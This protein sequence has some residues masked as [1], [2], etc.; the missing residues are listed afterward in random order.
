MRHASDHAATRLGRGDLESWHAR[1]SLRFWRPEDGD[2]RDRQA[3]ISSYPRGLADIRATSAAIARVRERAAVLP[4]PLLRGG[5][6]AANPRRRTLD[7][8]ERNAERS[9]GGSEPK[10]EEWVAPTAFSYVSGVS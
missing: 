1:R 4:S 7:M 8:R 10:R 3:T 5:E 9:S 2:L 6:S